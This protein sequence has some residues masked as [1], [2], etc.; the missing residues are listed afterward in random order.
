MQRSARLYGF[1]ALAVIG[2]A[3]LLI[4]VRPLAS[5]SL[6]QTSG[7]PVLVGAGDIAACN[8]PNDSATATL[9]DGI[10]GTVFVL[11]DNAYPSG[12][13]GEYNNCYA[14]TW[15]RHKARTKPVPGNHEYDDPAS[16]A[17]GYYTY[18]GAAAS[19]LET[20]C[21]NNCKG[22]YS[23]NLGA[24]HIVALNSEIDHSLD[25]AQL[26][27]L[28]DDL[29][30]HPSVC[31]LAYW[32]RPYYTSGP[33]QIDAEI[34][35]LKPFWDVLYAY[36]ADVVLNGHDHNYE[37]FARQ[38]PAGQADLERGIREFVVGT[39]GKQLR[40]L[41]TVLPNSEVRNSD[42][43]GVL[44]LTLHATS[45]TWQFIPIAGQT[46]TD[47]GIAD[48]ITTT[49]VEVTPIVSL[50]PPQSAVN[51]GDGNA[52]LTVQLSVTT[53]LPITVN[54]STSFT[55]APGPAD[56]T[57]G[58][59]YGIAADQ[60]V[61][62][63]GGQT[64]TTLAIPIIDDASVEPSERFSVTITL[65]A[66]SRAVLD[67]ANRTSVVTIADND[68]ANHVPVA[69]AQTVDALQATAKLIT[70][71]ASDANN[72]ELRYIIVTQPI[73]G[74]LSGIAPNLTYTPPV[75]FVGNDSFTFKVNDG[76][77]D[78]STA[79]VTIIVATTTPV[80]GNKVYLPLTPR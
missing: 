53:S 18:F 78:S 12:T 55:L 74:T 79:T 65:P 38:D 76:Q 5:A 6:S 24:W 56:A 28:R 44:Q 54:Y 67:L 21:T 51:E 37:R 13:F 64:T 75:G 31:T 39:G 70:L 80:A 77:V 68:G 48:C 29:A 32:H 60:T 69:H 45:Y 58:N 7:D 66:N 23:Y 25:S 33:H 46:F 20:N 15:G 41:G 47:T 11:G 72:D 40:A 35:G 30:A 9:L 59:D 43:Y 62:V 8:E 49:P 34:P 22:Y 26:Q 19:P 42:T 10:D 73:S 63:L 14:P 17:A 52:T 71:S 36:G 61:V 57:P 1:T 3:I 2:G 27:W 4:G 16:G 50:T